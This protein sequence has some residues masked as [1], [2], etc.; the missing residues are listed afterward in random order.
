MSGWDSPC[1]HG[2]TCVN[3]PGTFR[4]DCTIGYTGPRCEVNINECASSPCFNDG[5]CLDERGRYKCVC[6][7][8]KQS[9]YRLKMYPPLNKYCNS[10]FEKFEGGTRSRLAPTVIWQTQAFSFEL[11]DFK[12]MGLFLQ[13]T[14]TFRYTVQ[15]A[16]CQPPL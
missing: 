12:L 6:M 1:Y 15:P 16:P 9:F 7:D 2:G 4:C 8:G 3:V 5:T 14:V 10:D 13:L 11:G